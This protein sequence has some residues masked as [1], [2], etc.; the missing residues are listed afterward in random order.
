[1]TRRAVSSRISGSSLLSVLALLLT[2]LVAAPSHAS[3]SDARILDRVTGSDQVIIV[4]AANRSATA[5]SLRT[6]ER[7]GDG[8]RL[9]QSRTRAQLGY[10]GLVPAKERR[11]GTGATPIGTFAI[12]SSFGRAKDP[13]TRLDYIRVDRND[14]WTYNPRVPATYN[15]F[16]NANRSWASY[17]NYVEML[18]DYGYQ[19]D[20]VAIMDFNLPRGPISTKPNGVRVTEKPGDLRRGGGIFLHVDNGRKTAGCIAIDRGV[21]RDVMRWLDP[22]ADPVIVVALEK[23]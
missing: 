2:V 4:T 17:G 23:T 9:V 11:Q 6:Y 7:R 12:T 13:G 5:G 20:Y 19:Y 21:M 18:W 10:G 15:I 1:M 14:A 22:A 16:Q 3:S 8:W